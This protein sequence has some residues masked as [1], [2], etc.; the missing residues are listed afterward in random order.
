MELFWQAAKVATT[1]LDD[2]RRPNAAYYARRARIYEGPVKRR[3]IAKGKEIAGAVFGN[4]HR[5]V[6]YVDSRSHYCHAYADAVA[7]TS[8]FRLLFALFNV[9]GVPVLLL[10]PDAHPVAVDETWEQAYNDTKKPFGHERVLAV[11]LS[12]SPPEWP[13]MVSST[14]TASPVTTK[15]QRIE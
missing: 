5:L 12:L 11:M 14:T 10:G 3:Y 1:E 7:K 4:D 13:W 2:Q 15:R 6:S 8:A 9:L